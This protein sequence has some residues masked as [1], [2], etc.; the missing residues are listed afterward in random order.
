M[1]ST[2]LRHFTLFND[3]H[4]VEFVFSSFYSGLYQSIDLFVPLKC[5]ALRNDNKSADRKH[6]A[7]I[8][9]LMNREAKAWRDFHG[10][11]SPATLSVYEQH[12]VN[13]F[14][15]SC[16]EKLIDSGNVGPFY[17]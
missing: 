7:N 3:D 9:R 6:P 5:V 13:T 15:S 8:R 14:I 11:R 4:S 12:A 17:R 1:C 10:S 2:Y 16:E